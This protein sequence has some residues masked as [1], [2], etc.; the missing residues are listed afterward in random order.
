MKSS[1]YISKAFI[2]LAIPFLFACE[3]NDDDPHHDHNHDEG[4]LITLLGITL[5]NPA[6]NDS[7]YAVFSDPDG[8]GG[9][10]PTITPIN[11]KFTGQNDQYLAYV[12]VLDTSNPNDIEDITEEIIEEADSHQFFYIPDT[13]AAG[14]VNVS[15]DAGAATDS[16]GNPIG[17]HTVWDV[18]GLTS[19]GEITIVLRHS[20]N[21]GGAG[22]SN[23][24]IANA[25]GDTDIE[26]TFPLIIQ[27]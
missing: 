5:I 17:I 22:V 24:D 6:T 1:N 26:V 16:N 14:V 11:L 3:G 15:Y 10:A 20:P 12:E 25:G 9:N 2:F 23:G 18:S 13:E 4:E 19:Q 8:P 27:P 7:T 21:K